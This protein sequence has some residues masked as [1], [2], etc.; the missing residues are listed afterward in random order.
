[1]AKIGT[2]GIGGALRPKRIKRTKNPRNRPG[3]KRK[4]PYRGQG[5]R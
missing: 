4:K 1:M 2:G 5:K 3:M